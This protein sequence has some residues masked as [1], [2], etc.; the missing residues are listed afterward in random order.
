MSLWNKAA[1][2]AVLL[3]LAGCASAASPAIT[4]TAPL[5][6]TATTLP[7]TAVST[8]IVGVSGAATAAVATVLAPVSITAAPTATPTTLGT[9]SATSN[10]AVPNAQPTGSTP[11]LADLKYRLIN[12]LAGGSSKAILYCDPD[13]YPVAR[14]G[15]EQTKAPQQ[16]PAIQQDQATFQAILTQLNLTGTTNF[17][18][19]QQVLIYR[20]YK[21]L[22]ALNLQPT[23]GGY[24]FQ[25]VYQTS[26]GI[27]QVNG[28]IGSD[29][30]ITVQQNTA[31]SK[32]QCPICL[33]AGTLID[34]PSGQIAVKDLQV[35]MRVWTL[36]KHGN[37][38]TVPI[39]KTA[40][41]AVR[42]GHEVVHLRL[43]DGRELWASPP[44]PTADGRALGS[45]QLGDSLD[46]AIVISVG[47]VSYPDNSTYD[48][49]P[50]GDTG[51]YWANG[52]LMGSTLTQSTL[53]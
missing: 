35:G 1:A 31:G 53:F 4:P 5:S 13:F 18:P 40:R 8:A 27:F 50:A 36:D 41:V 49:L 10:A 52:I 42:Y 12:Q 51:F 43:S 28:T 11:S 44:H 2:I 38:Q 24:T 33:V 9:A 26:S 34:T 39:L 48:I 14:L 17:T 15:I 47:Q 21:T 22:R 29:G 19:D 37:R 3:A 45:L 32:P 16:F 20:E 46:G 25:I 6:P 7:L 30:Q 23:T